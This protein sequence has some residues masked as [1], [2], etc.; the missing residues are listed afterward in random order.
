M[1]KLLVEDSDNRIAEFK[2][3]H[4]DIIVCKTSQCGIDKLMMIDH[5]DILFLD[6]DLG[7]ETFVPSFEPNTGM[8]VVRWIEKNNPSIGRVIIHSWNPD[9]AKYM[10]MALDR[11]G[12]DVVYI[13]FGT[14]GY[15]GLEEDY[16][17]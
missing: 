6:H 12:Y 4:P 14:K 5:V 17:P 15:L 10:R 16:I 8:E 7:G 9:G 2:H 3:Y 1:I 11:A 13:P